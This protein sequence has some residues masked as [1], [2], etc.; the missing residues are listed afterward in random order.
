MA[1]NPDMKADKLSKEE[2]ASDY[3]YAVE[4][5][6]SNPEIAA[7]FEKAVKQQWLPNRFKAGLQ[8]TNWY[9]QNSQYAR[10]TFIKKS[11]GGADW[12]E[13]LNTA[14]EIVQARAT[15]VGSTLTPEELNSLAYRVL[16]EGMDR[17]GRESL[18]DKA[19]SENIKVSSEGFLRGASG[20][21]A[22]NL[23]TLAEANGVS[24]NDDFYVSAAKS[25]NSNLSTAEDWERDIR[26]R[27]ASLFPVYSDKIRAGVNAI[28]LASPYMTLM[29]ED[30][31]I[32]AKEISLDDPYIREALGGF[33][34][35][36][37]PEPTNL[38]DFR[39]KIRS[40]PRWMCT[41]KAN[42]EIA[43]SFDS[44]LKIFGVR[45]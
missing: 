18:L 32:N 2:L 33:S 24:F 21:L 4:V 15:T 1:K 10:E 12:E 7:L 19:L 16:N 38:W 44:L 5:I 8:N 20:D 31:E 14:K 42:N 3:G 25:V 17:P 9:K 41:L 34:S 28:D 27:A 30:L 35:N 11:M 45:K 6:Y 36:G 29:G 39:K 13:S 23:R 40:D 37:T 22:D 26:E 43:G